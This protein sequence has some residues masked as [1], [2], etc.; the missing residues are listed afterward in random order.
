MCVNIKYEFSYFY[1]HANV[2]F[3]VGL[4]V[5]ADICFH[6][7]TYVYIHVYMSKCVHI[8]FKCLIVYVCAHLCLYVSICVLMQLSASKNAIICKRVQTYV[9]QVRIYVCLYMCMHAYIHMLENEKC[10]CVYMNLLICVCKNTI[11]LVY[12]SV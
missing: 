12:I 6:L 11:I 8:C 7:S 2:C 4:Y 10:A 3:S 1:V 5:W 9:L